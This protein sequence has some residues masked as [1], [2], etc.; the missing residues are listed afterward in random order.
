[1]FQIYEKEVVKAGIKFD[2]GKVK[3]TNLWRL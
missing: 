3:W 1:M 2:L